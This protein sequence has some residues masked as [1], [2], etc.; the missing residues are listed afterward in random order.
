M[1]S[2]NS[3]L[4]TV[5]KVFGDSIADCWEDNAVQP[6]PCQGYGR[7]AAPLPGPLPEQAAGRLAKGFGLSYAEEP[8]R[9]YV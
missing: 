8:C 9:G 6:Y 3:Q 4:L 2:D 5:L 1:P 7:G